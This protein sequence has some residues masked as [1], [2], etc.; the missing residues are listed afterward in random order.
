MRA[1]FLSLVILSI[2]FL[3]SEGQVK[4][5][6]QDKDH[7]ATTVVVKNSKKLNDMEILNDQFNLNSVGMGQV[8]RITTGD[9]NKPSF[10]EMEK[11]MLEE[12]KVEA[13]MTASSDNDAVMEYLSEEVIEKEKTVVLNQKSN[14]K[15]V[16]KEEIK[17]TQEVVQEKEAVRPTKKYKKESTTKTSSTSTRKRKRKSS[18]WFSNL[19]QKKPKKRKRRKRNIN[20][21]YSF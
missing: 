3:P 13:T 14:T 17:I 20:K 11:F 2:S 5:K 15:I 9:R 6:Y 12:D 4:A 16:Q 10:D 7:K 1:I 18:N 19:F 21:C 8:I